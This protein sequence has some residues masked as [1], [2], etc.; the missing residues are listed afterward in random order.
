MLGRPCPVPHRVRLGW[1]P[2]EIAQGWG[3]E[4][5][6]EEMNNPGVFAKLAL[7]RAF[8]QRQ[9]RAVAFTRCNTTSKS[10][11]AAPHNEQHG[12]N[13][14]TKCSHH[15]CFRR[16]YPGRQH[17]AFLIAAIVCLTP[18]SLRISVCSRAQPPTAWRPRFEQICRVE[19]GES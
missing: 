8:H 13:S 4:W 15:A 17:Y 10:N 19:M 14:A 7:N 6:P 1:L 11:I 5:H 3:S 2:S 12:D 9:L 18:H 16:G